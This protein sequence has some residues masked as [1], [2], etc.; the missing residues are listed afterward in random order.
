M[1]IRAGTLELVENDYELLFFIDGEVIVNISQSSTMTQLF[2]L[3]N[4]KLLR[5]IIMCFMNNHT[6]TFNI[7][8][9]STM[10]QLYCVEDKRYL[11]GVMCLLSN[12]NAPSKQVSATSETQSTQHRRQP[13]SFLLQPA[14]TSLHNINRLITTNACAIIK[15]KGQVEANNISSLGSPLTITHI[16]IVLP[17]VL[18]GL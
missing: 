15:W 8:P 12:H 16:F 18:S 11:R 7:S 9:L 4:R 3:E 2:F 14:E 17:F 13:F 1:N 5:G 6:L 10:T